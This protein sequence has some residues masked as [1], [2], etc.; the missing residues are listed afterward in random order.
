[1][2]VALVHHR[3]SKVG[4]LE[5]RM[6]NYIQYFIDKGDD[7]C[8]YCMQYDKS[9]AIDPKVDIRL[10]KPG[11]ELKKYRRWHFN[12]RLEKVFNPNEFDF[13]L[14]MERTS[15][16]VA[17]IGPG[18]HLGY[19]AATNNTQIKK[20]DRLQIELDKACFHHSKAIYPC[21]ELIKNN[22]QNLY[23][24]DE[25]KLCVLH[26]PLNS[27][28]FNLSHGT[29]KIQMA[30]KYD[31]SKDKLTFVIVSTSHKRKGVFFL[32]ELFALLDP[33]KFELKIAGK[34]AIKSH[35]KNVE[36]LGYVPKTE[37]LFAAA[38][39]T[40]HPSI[41]EPFGQV[42]SESLACGTPVVLSKNTGWSP[43]LPKNYGI[44]V[45]E[46]DLS[47]W[48]N[49]LENLDPNSFLID[50]NFTDKYE[51]STEQHMQKMLSFY[52]SIS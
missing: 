11:W 25:K 32:L 38:D 39:F 40:L 4:G 20:S 52:R 42:I 18:D 21:S 37:E 7:V 15:Q 9:L 10:I 50:E 3:L 31:C 2:K 28:R 27:S 8:V 26:P 1:M 6:L 48:K 46:L 47:K 5:S 13:S 41:F 12:K 51:L 16:Q 19:M 23:G 33:N 43:H 36:F 29:N 45:D 22:I 49:T 24:I 17:S 30:E 35:L 34:P 44:V 14:T